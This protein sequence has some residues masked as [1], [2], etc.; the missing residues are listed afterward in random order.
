MAAVVQN[1]QLRLGRPSQ[2]IDNAR[3]VH[4]RRDDVPVAPYHEHAPVLP[5]PGHGFVG[6]HK[7]VQ[8]EIPQRGE[9]RGEESWVHLTLPAQYAAHGGE[10]RLESGV[11]RI[12]M[13]FAG[14]RPERNRAQNRHEDVPEEGE[15]P[16]LGGPRHVDGQA[17]GRQEGESPHALRMQVREMH[18]DGPPHRGPEY[19]D[20]PRAKD[21]LEGKKQLRQLPRKELDIAGE[22][23]VAVAAAVQVKGQD[24]TASFR[25]EGVRHVVPDDTAQ[26]EAMDQDNGGKVRWRGRLPEDVVDAAFGEGDKLTAGFLEE[27]LADDNTWEGARGIPGKG[28][29]SAEEDGQGAHKKGTGTKQ[30]PSSLLAGH[31]HGTVVAAGAKSAASGSACHHGRR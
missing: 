10:G 29:R 26:G 28:D 14:I 6:P 17:S 3:G 15:L 7:V 23:G 25:D 13:A 8:R 1:Q 16:K 27:I 4:E 18:G 22:G 19:I 12:G 31:L 11:V 24:P 5:G 30:R 21:W 9:E 20:R 2:Q